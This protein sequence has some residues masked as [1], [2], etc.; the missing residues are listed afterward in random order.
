MSLTIFNVVVYAVVRH[1]V[2][3][4]AESADE[5]SR[6]RQEGMQKISLFYAYDGM[7]GGSSEPWQS[8]STVWTWRQK[9]GRQSEWS[10]A[11]SRR[12]EHSRRQLTG[13]ILHVRGLPTG[14]G[15]V[16][17]YSARSVGRRWRSVCWQ[18]I[19]RRSMGR[20]R[21]DDGIGKPRLPVGSHVP[22]GWPYQPTGDCGTA[23]LRGVWDGR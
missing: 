8:C 13:N 15:S 11:C 14:R 21:V 1:L 22:I 19:D 2:E 4:T 6:H 18:S 5:Q 16:F 3:V 23:P 17:G 20:Q 10:A 9:L 7:V 12:R